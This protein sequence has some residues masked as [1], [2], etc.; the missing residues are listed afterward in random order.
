MK[1]PLIALSCYCTRVATYS[2][3]KYKLVD[4]INLMEA[5]IVADSYCNV[6]DI[7]NAQECKTL[8]AT[9][10]HDSCTYYRDL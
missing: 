9:R 2:Q 3:H 8:T 10:M 4:S 5:G 7:M 6:H 1:V